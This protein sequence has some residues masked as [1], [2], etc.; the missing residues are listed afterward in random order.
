MSDRPF[1]TTITDAPTLDRYRSR[2]STFPSPV[3]PSRLPRVRPET[4]VVDVP[5]AGGF[6]STP[7]RP[8]AFGTPV[9]TPVRSFSQPFSVTSHTVSP[10][11]LI[12]GWDGRPA[13]PSPPRL[14]AGWYGQPS[15]ITAEPGFEFSGIATPGIQQPAFSG[16][17]DFGGFAGVDQEESP[18]PID[19]F[20]FTPSTPTFSPRSPPRSPR[21][22][23]QSPPRSPRRQYEE[24]IFSC[25]Q[26]S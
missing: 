19:D 2:F 14:I 12:A 13:S 6:S 25:R 5:P 11:G 17:F 21:F 24:S 10:P 15:M 22:S 4:F 9:G 7:P 20:S 8:T 1:T 3:S 23:P 18:L 16:G 26:I